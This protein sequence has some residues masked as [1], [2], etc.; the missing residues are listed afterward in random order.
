MWK[1]GLRPRYS[2]PGNICF[3]FSA[4]CLRSVA[5]KCW[6]RASLC[7]Y[8][9]PWGVAGKI[10]QLY[11]AEPRNGPEGKPDKRSNSSSQ[12][13][14]GH[15]VWEERVEEDLSSRVLNSFLCTSS[16]RLILHRRGFLF[17]M[18]PW[19][20][21]PQCCK[22]ALQYFPDEVLVLALEKLVVSVSITAL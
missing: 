8:L 14:F 17:K 11:R 7:I 20:R 15:V 12:F 21:D 5:A 10:F 22:L 6:K 18:Q 4:F 9:V 13:N 19:K 1:L 16:M 2:F 3:K